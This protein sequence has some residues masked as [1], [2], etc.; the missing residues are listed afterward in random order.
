MNKA[1]RLEGHKVCTGEKTYKLV[2]ILPVKSQ[3][4]AVACHLNYSQYK[5]VNTVFFVDL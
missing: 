3:K 5:R 1:K 4:Q 2:L